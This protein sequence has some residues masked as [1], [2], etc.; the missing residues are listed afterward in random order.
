MKTAKKPYSLLFFIFFVFTLHQAQSQSKVTVYTDDFA[1][2]DLELGTGKYDY[3]ML[4]RSGVTTV[5]SVKIPTGM[6]VTLYTQDN[7]QGESIVLTENARTSYLQAKGFGQITQ[8]NSLVVAQLPAEAT[9]GPVATI[10][11][12]NFSG[13]SKKLAA[14]YYDFY[15]LGS[16]D[17]DQLSSVK[18][19]KGMKVTLYEH[20][21]LGGRSLVL[22]ADASASFL[23]S[24]NFNDLTSSIQ[25]E[26]VPEPTPVPVSPV[27]VVP[28][29][30]VN[31][32]PVPKQ[33]IPIQN[34][35][36]PAVIFYEGDYADHSKELTPGNYDLGELP[37][38]NDELSSVKIPS[39]MWVLLFEHRNFSGRSLLLTQ[40]AS[41]DFMAGR[42]FDNLT[43][44]LI[45]GNAK[46]PLPLVLLYQDN[47]TEP[48]KKLTP[49]KYPVLELKN[50]IVSTIE[51][52]RGLRVTL[53]DKAA[54]GGKSIM[55]TKSAGVE[56]LKK[57][58][59]DKPIA[60]LIVEQIPPRDQVVTIYQDSFGGQSQDLLPGKYYKSD[61]KVDD[62]L[63]SIRVPSGM[64]VTLYEHDG[65]K[66]L[67]D[68][69]YRDTD[70]TGSN[71]LDNLYSSLVVEDDYEPMVKS[72]PTIETTPVVA[73]SVP[74]VVVQVVE[75]LSEPSTV[76]YNHDPPCEITE[77]EYYTALKAVESK[78]FSAEKMSTARLATKGKCMT[79][80]QIRGIAKLF[81][82]EEQ[83][84]EFIK[85]A[86]DLATEKST[87]YA[88]ED[89][90]K[91]MSSKDAF[92]KFLNSRPAVTTTTTTNPIV[93]P[94]PPVVVKTSSADLIKEAMDFSLKFISTYF[95]E[96]CD[97]YFQY[98][99]PELI[100]YE[101]GGTVSVTGE[102]KN[103]L[104]ERLPRAVSDN[105]K[106]LADYLATHKIELLT[107]AQV[108][109]KVGRQLPEFFNTTDDEFYFIGTEPKANTS[110][111]KYIWDEMFSFLVRKENGIWKMKALL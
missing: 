92:N 111:E 35:S 55:L 10:Y 1:G 25:V 57:R 108:E 40:S 69:V 31:P 41:A 24:K 83:T 77:K 97:T 42:D 62:Q 71:L 96:D 72:D 47:Y 36:T 11:K 54:F 93:T 101:R 95:T 85:Y 46:N 67:I 16:V 52:P 65:F 70:Y 89:V 6:S 15:E 64:R 87:Y 107:R 26:F 32:S 61:L 20:K 84:L 94:I 5:R 39:G 22:T 37:I 110:G 19:P 3:M 2:A 49:G 106:T 23:V 79:N 78:P 33:E 43:S 48:L 9:T 12:D 29:V 82:F 4:V 18:V 109:A 86:Y 59:F 38:S 105:T 28:I 88:L 99:S 27:V 75:P 8:N 60:S 34:A 45:V 66:G 102:I 80:D 63:S 90:F 91:F 74:V 7:F 104:C 50:N 81:D 21:E 13:A 56:F 73:P 76:V 44:S 100:V 98:V 68:I 58:G 30:V 53:F 51:I 17:N 14:G 103:K